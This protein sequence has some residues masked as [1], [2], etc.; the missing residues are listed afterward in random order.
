MCEYFPG[1]GSEDVRLPCVT[2][3]SFITGSIM[4]NSN[5]SNT[6]DLSNPLKYVIAQDSITI[7]NATAFDEGVYNCTYTDTDQIRRDGGIEYYLIALGMYL[8]GWL[9]GWLDGWMDG[10][11]DGSN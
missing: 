2:G 8:A 11:M 4:W 10:W 7:V 3:P 1:D 5:S 6:I 9:A